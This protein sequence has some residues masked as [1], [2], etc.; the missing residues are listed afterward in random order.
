MIQNQEKSS[1]N[2][3]I[4]GLG[5]HRSV[6]CDGLSDGCQ[7]YLVARI[8]REKPAPMTVVLPS[9]KDAERFIMDFLFFSDGDSREL[10]YFAPYNL[11]PFKF[12]SYHSST[13]AERL[14]ALYQQ[15]SGP[16]PC[17]TVTT[18][19]ALQRKL[20]P[21]KAL[22]DFA[23]LIMTNEE[24][25]RDLLLAKLIAGGYTRS[26]LV[27]EPGDFC[28]RGGI[29]DIFS[30]TYPEPIRIE[31]FGD[32]VESIRFFSS[33]NQ[34][35]L[36]NVDE[37]V[38]LPA[39]ES[40]LDME[41]INEITANIRAQASRLELPASA[42][43]E[44][45]DRIKTNGGFSGIEGLLP[46]IYT[47]L[48][49]LFDYTPADG[50][51]VLAEPG[52]LRKLADETLA[53]AEESF[54]AAVADRRVCVAPEALYLSWDDIES[55]LS[56]R[57]TLA[58]RLL[59]FT[60]PGGAD[61]G[62][63]YHVSTGDTTFLREKVSP[64][65][66]DASPFA[67]MADWIRENR[68]A[69]R[70]TVFACGNRP[71]SE[72][73]ATLLA[74]YGITPVPL[75]AFAG[76][77]RAKGAVFLVKGHLSAGFTW[78][79]ESIAVV[80]EADIFGPGAPRRKAAPRT[81]RAEFLS[82]DE[83]KAGDLVVHA[84]HGI[85]R[86]QGLKKLTINHA[87]NDFLEIFFR[88]DDKLYLPVDRMSMIQKYMGVEGIEPILDKMG[89]GSWDAVKAKVRKSVEKIAGDLLKVYAER[90]V[91]TGFAFHLADT[92][93]AAFE[94]GFPFEETPDQ[95]RAIQDV[96]EDMQKPTAMDRLV[97]GDVGY[98]K[99]EVVL[100]A[101]YVAAC[102]GKQVAVLVPT[103]V[104]AEQH[105]ET[106]SQRFQN[107]PFHIAC[108]SRFRSAK[109]QRSIVEGLAAGR[110]D[111]VVG[112]H[113]LLQKDI[114]FQ[115]L[116][117][118]ILDEEQRFGVKHKERLKSFRSTVDVLA[119]TATPIP[120][121]LH[122][123]LTGIRDISVI[124]TPPEA[125]R[126]IITYISEFEE[127]VIRDAVRKELKRKGQIFFVHN[128]I[129]TIERMAERLQEIVPEVRL[130]IAHGRMGEDDLEKVMMRFL[131]QEV[132]MLVCTTI[133]ES[134]LDVPGANTIL[135]N[136]AD[137]LGLAQ[138]YQLRG[139]V[140]RADE[141]A[142]AYLFI[143]EESGL[144]KDA[145]KR[146][147]VLMEHSDL[148]AGFQI[149]MSDLRIRGGGTI[150]GASQSGHIA[151]VGYDMFLKL[152]EDA[153]SELKGE[154]I[155]EPLE[156][157][158]NIPMSF[159]IPESYIPDIDQRM[160]AYRRLSRMTAVR[161]ISEFRSELVDRFGPLT[162]ET[163]NLLLKIMLKILA[164]KAGVKRLDLA[165]TLLSL[166]FSE[167][168]QKNPFGIVDLITD[169]PDRFTFTPDHV[170]KV[171]IPRGAIG[172]RLAQTKNT[173]KEIAQRVN[174]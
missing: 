11:S 148:G 42:A 91:K 171:K 53:Q 124:S 64:T 77:R 129:H 25:D 123:S 155:R 112:T 141:Q 173:L 15:T 154:P 102:N 73:L 140:G 110:L 16:R 81:A 37:V 105:F 9:A 49:T 139:R 119:L 166:H 151:A 133:I 104:L 131:Y 144:G 65:K 115:D 51:V 164:A 84:E 55:R 138:I 100:R 1:I 88:D 56:T 61:L 60:G 34:R 20:I 76:I 108:L 137:R 101:A 114:V 98:G 35:T 90:S 143:P 86:Y 95:T 28:V 48:D 113:R 135:V 33:S 146:L 52:R 71:R 93:L 159:F 130:D 158:I 40:I 70:T 32:L 117:L 128:N 134:G 149:A 153:V 172:A 38:I 58:M 63:R 82:L 126:P 74:P 94:A 132:D 92:D 67:P 12:V 24:I 5:S 145:Q 116:G 66:P 150:L 2:D 45:I 127:G 3:I 44:V 26:A 30:P 19:E 43:R 69:D 118:I 99:T 18:V 122:M 72:R 167:V 103:T 125:R 170:L 120:R 39:K 168:H 160:S 83:L 152:M 136:R 121:T 106:F 107:T 10:L 14:R 59:P 4:A 46:L 142:F 89:G 23:E 96:L 174:G 68:A 57:R 78:P 75:E 109:E 162:E 6:A 7:A 87:A 13:T 165:E 111:I 169:R 80:T 8:F 156:P 17:V 54:T 62:A 47:R 161:E 22:N 27:E 29:I 31:M 79:S 97:C 147:K 50:L 21:K 41:R 85:G 36:Q 163:G 157:E